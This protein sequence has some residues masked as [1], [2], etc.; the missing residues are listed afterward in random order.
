[1]LLMSGIPEPHCWSVM[2]MENCGAETQFAHMF[3]A[4]IPL[5]RLWAV[6]RLR[7]ALLCRRMC[8]GG[9]QAPAEPLALPLAEPLRMFTTVCL[10]SRLVYLGRLQSCVLQLSR[11]AGPCYPRTQGRHGHFSHSLAAHLESLE[12]KMLFFRPIC[13]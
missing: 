7:S 12:S 2:D 8:S 6:P 4:V 11:S 5:K 3:W 1:M 10:R 13:S 9:P